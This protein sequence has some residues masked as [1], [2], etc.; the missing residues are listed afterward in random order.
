M[1]VGSSNLASQ[2]NPREAAGFFLPYFVL[3][4]TIPCEFF[5]KFEMPAL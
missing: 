4:F 1:N 2:K 3:F 5:S